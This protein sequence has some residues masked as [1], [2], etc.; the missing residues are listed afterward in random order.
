M[1]PKSNTNRNTHSAY[2][3]M[4]MCSVDNAT[5]TSVDTTIDSR[6][7]IGSTI[8][9]ATHELSTEVTTAIAGVTL[10]D[11]AI[12][13]TGFFTISATFTSTEA[14]TT[15]ITQNPSESTTESNV[16][17]STGGLSTSINQNPSVPTTVLDILT[18]IEAVPISTTQYPPES[19]TESNVQTSI[20]AMTTSITQNSPVLTT[21]SNTPTST[22]DVTT[23]ITQNPSVSST[24]SNTSTATESMVYNQISTTITSSSVPHITTISPL[25]SSTNIAPHSHPSAST[26][27]ILPSVLYA[28]TAAPIPSDQSKSRTCRKHQ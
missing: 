13:S 21:V 26:S 6:T 20:G 19:T 2:R 14:V 25:Q 10:N 12:A 23:S 8:V 1:T 16:S 27:S 11:E 4:N 18:S 17:T 28:Q 5:S 7:A 3:S 15:S 22:D 9:T 24:M